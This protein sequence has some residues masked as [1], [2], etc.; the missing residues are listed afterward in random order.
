MSE[1]IQKLQQVL[2][3]LLAEQNEQAEALLHEYVVDKARSE[4]VRVLDEADEVEF[5]ES[6]DEDTVEET[7][8]QSN[9]FEDDIITDEDEIEFDETGL[10]E[11]ED[12]DEDEFDVEGDDEGDEDIEDKVDEL[13]DEIEELRAEFEKMMAGD[14]QPMDD[15]EE[16]DMD[17]DMD[18][19]DAEMDMDDAEME[20]VEYDLDEDF[21]SEE[22]EVVEEATNFSSKTAMPKAGEADAGAGKSPFSNPPKHTKVSSQ[23]SPV[24]IKD[25]GEGR[26][27]HGSKPK[28]Q[29]PTNRNIN[30]DHKKGPSAVDGKSHSDSSNK[31][32]PLTKAPR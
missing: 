21:D 13:A 17:M 30:V 6:A 4:Y 29:N 31:A 8:D 22:D 2:E 9:D 32:S 20:S 15:A 23:G 26:G 25:G 24:K 3:L 10:E 1:S 28:S 18:M 19:D 27:D 14:D 7:I 5:D 12:E 16:A 11:D